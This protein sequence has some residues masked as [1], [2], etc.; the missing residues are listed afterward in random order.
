MPEVKPET[1]LP[2]LKGAARRRLWPERWR[3]RV[4]LVLAVLIVLAGALAWYN[5]EQ[6][7]GDLID[8]T[9]TQYGL[10]ASYE[11]EDIGTR[12]QVIKN[13]VVGDPA[14]PD[15]TAKRVTL[16]ISYTYGPPEIGQVEL[17]GARLFGSFRENALSFGSLNPII[18]AESDEP[19]GLPALN[20]R[21]TDGRALLQTDYGDIGAKLEGE[22]RLDDGFAG[23]LAA[24]APGIGIQTCKADAL[25][26]YGDVTSAD[27]RLSF[28]G[29][30]RTRDIDCEGPLI[31]AADIGM[32]LTLSE[33]FESVEGDMALSVSGLSGPGAMLSRLGGSANVAWRFGG[34][35]SLR[36][37]LNG[38]GLVT[39]YANAQEVGTQG[40]LRSRESFARNDWTA[41]FS[42]RG[43]NAQALLQGAASSQAHVATA[44]TFA[45]TL[46]GKF[47]DA[48]AVAVTGSSFAGD[49][50]LRTQ[51]DSL[52]L[53]IPEARLRSP[54]G[55][56]LF[57]LSRINYAGA[58]N[59]QPERLAG[60]IL[61]GGAGL[62]RINARFQQ[63]DAGST[64]LRMTMAEYREGG[65][66]ISIPRLEA[67]QDIAGRVGFSGIIQA[68]GAIPGGNVRGL[69]LSVDGGWSRGSGLRL[70]SRCLDA[71]FTA[72]EVYD[73]A[74]RN[75]NLSICT[76]AGK[77]LVSYDRELKVEA[78]MNDVSLSGQYGE[79]PAGI[80][81]DSAA[82]HYP[83]G[84]S[85][86]GVEATLG[87]GEETMCLAFDSFDGSFSG[88][89]EGG[90]AGGSAILGAASVDLT[91]LTGQ[92]KYAN[93]AWQVSEG[94]FTLSDRQPSG[95]VE[96]ARFEPI[97]GT[98]GRLDFVDGVVRATI[99][100]ENPWSGR[101]LADV[102]IG[103]DLASA[104]GRAD[105]TVPGIKFDEGFQPEELTSLTRGVI[106]FV[107]GEVKGRG[108]V[109][110]EGEELTSSGAFSSDGFD[111]AAA[112]GPVRGV[113]G[114]IEFTDLINLT[115]APSQVATIESVNSGVE[116]L[117]GRVVYSVEN[118]TLITVEDGRW[119]FM[120]GELILRPVKLDYGGG[121]GQSYIF[122]IVA[123]DA[124]TFVTQ[125]ELTNLGATGEFDGTIP[126]IFDAQGNGTIDGGLLISR[127]PGGNVS[128][129]G[130]LSYE[131]LGAMGN[132]AFQ[133]LRSL[134]YNQM[135]IELNGNLAGE[136]L[137]NFN[138]D[139]VRQGEGTNQNFITR[140][141][142]ELPIR[143]KI[144]VRSENF[145]LLATIVR[146]LF[147]PTVFGDP[148]DQG[149][150]QIDGQRIVPRG[151]DEPV[152][153]TP[154]PIIT[155]GEDERRNEP[156]V[157]PP[158][159][160][161]EL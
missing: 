86:E 34:E 24:T 58:N 52:R 22:G 2:D 82:L 149:L 38:E 11:I 106:A 136:I 72:L 54:S 63:A 20:L 116:V 151:N 122:E 128:Y 118:G 27:G 98:G 80:T 29:P 50:S 108:A 105:F 103:H 28:D 119:P 67:R 84:F 101:K 120:G 127:S 74:I 131:D 45:G 154:V 61:T 37:D 124:A 157:Q 62:P 73:F 94:A 36:H 5:R 146:G 123:L 10:Q 79:S 32:R 33:D 60:N 139:G 125:M 140:Q 35:L 133:A 141:L 126:I 81:I 104:K 21:I 137:T 56:T 92:W 96:P 153:Q 17:V 49:V 55:E 91:D 18:F 95:S 3:W 44:G 42:G 83:G 6:I 152:P 40:T 110:W 117:D 132:Y 26:L 134:D 71:K 161:S 138:I 76:S 107:N 30:L 4:S 155:P 65:D 88:G 150:F 47:E 102:V 113:K 160:D 99:G 156:F 31:E 144:N 25:T 75:E 23:K 158:E 15:L 114:T 109:T 70:G 89:F 1:D 46:L 145:Y 9:L 8:D 159:S 112:F 7:A 111:F 90:F 51:P 59:D 130:E 148:V 16:D 77:S 66:A 64:T 147:D 69:A 85:V 14:S 53:V 13:L 142:A 143:F 68:D 129:V 48:F 43:V 121:K 100:M 135:S 41:R 115:T 87:V 19:A 12:R 93:D 39:D 97:R 57:A 78:R